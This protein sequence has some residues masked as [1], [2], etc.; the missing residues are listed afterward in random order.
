MADDQDNPGINVPPPLIY[1]VPLVLGLLLD[2]RA[3]LPFLPRGAARGLG[4]PLLEA[5]PLGCQLFIF[6]SSLGS[7]QSAFIVAVFCLIDW[8]VVRYSSNSLTIHCL[9]FLCRERGQTAS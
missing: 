1:V 3:H 7:S 5:A 8:V 2:R 4:W 9:L 6:R